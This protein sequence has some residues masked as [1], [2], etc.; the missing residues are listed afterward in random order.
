MANL[1]FKKGFLALAF[2]SFALPQKHA[3][4]MD[5]AKSSIHAFTSLVSNNK[6]T[7]T[8]AA[9]ITVT[10]GYLYHRLA[11]SYK[12]L[13]WDWSNPTYQTPQTFPKGFLFG[14]GT[15]AHQVEGNCTNNTWSE[16]EKLKD[17]QGNPRVESPS[18]LACDHWI[19]Y[20][21][22]IKLMLHGVQNSRYAIL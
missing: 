6:L 15:S 3:N 9:A 14:T 5:Y 21:E 8:I 16:W 10:G 13:R 4:A 18:G 20:K 2:L 22:D 1:T 7:V 11:Q 19:R 12:P 17:E